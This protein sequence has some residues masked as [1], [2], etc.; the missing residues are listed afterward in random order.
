MEKELES[1]RIV[2]GPRIE[3][4]YRNPVTGIYE[5]FPPLSLNAGTVETE[6]VGDGADCR[7]HWIIESPDGGFSKGECS[8]CHSERDFSNAGY[9]RPPS[10]DENRAGKAWR[11][12]KGGTNGVGE[13]N[14]EYE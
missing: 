3:F 12:H 10:G 4:P 11:Q 7:H 2:I 1:K 8:H 13:E 5:A 14:S 6:L 9:T